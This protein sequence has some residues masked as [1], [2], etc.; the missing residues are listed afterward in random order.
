M[1]RRSPQSGVRPDTVLDNMNTAVVCLDH[2]LNVTYVNPA[3]EILFG[4]SARH[5]RGEP[6]D[7]MLPYLAAQQGHLRQA[8][9]DGAA[10]T[11]REL[12]LKHGGGEPITVDC[13]ATPFTDRNGEPALLLELMSLDRQLRI[14]RDDQMRVQHL[15]NR[16]MLRGL[17]HEIKNPLG[18]LRGAA[19]LL[20]REFADPAAHEYTDIIIR[21]ADRLQNLVDGMLGP[22]RPPR[23][24]PLNIH[25]ALEHVR[26]LLEADLPEDVH[27]VRDYDPSLPE[28]RGDREQLIQVFFNLMGNAVQA[29]DASGHIALRTRSQRQFTIG[30]RQHRLVVRVDIVDDGPGIPEELLPKIFHPMVTSRADGTGLGLPIAQYL[31]HL[32]DGLIECDSRPGDTRFSVFLPRDG[33]DE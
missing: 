28:I 6:L 31:V 10:Y 8:L 7:R 13:T 30:G 11:E 27:I 20:A 18:G 12:K 25:E 16:E 2:G 26:Q 21:E 19:Q 14:S 33:G 1:N 22:R 9:D 32:H 3:S 24:T 4:V 17:A 5:C 23:M 15:A 29:L